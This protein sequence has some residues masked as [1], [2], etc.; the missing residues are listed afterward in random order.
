MWQMLRGAIIIFAGI[1][2]VNTKSFYVIIKFSKSIFNFND[3]SGLD[4]L[5]E[6]HI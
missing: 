6:D 1:L 4:S 3:G 5:L 2:S